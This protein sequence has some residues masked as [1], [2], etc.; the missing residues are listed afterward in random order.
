MRK[1]IVI[2]MVMLAGLQVVAKA[3][4]NPVS[5]LSTSSSMLYLKFDKSMFGGIIEIRNEEDSVVVSEHINSKK[6]I[7]DFFERKSGKYFVKIYKGDLVECFSY[8]ILE[9]GDLNQARKDAL[10]AN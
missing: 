5:I 8:T 2:T 4:E 6:M 3:G 10:A 7:V 9:P 1:M